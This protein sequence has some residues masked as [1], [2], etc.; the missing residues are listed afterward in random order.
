M[1]KEI[2]FLARPG[3]VI[4]EVAGETMLVPVDT[5]SIHLSGNERLPAFNGMVR[6]NGLGLFLWK[7]LEGPKTLAQLV[8]AVENSFETQGRDVPADVSTFLDTGVR[9]QVIFLVP[10]NHQ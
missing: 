3:F 2:Q 6:L 9:N 8:A 5:G 7:E 1:E 4:R 10:A